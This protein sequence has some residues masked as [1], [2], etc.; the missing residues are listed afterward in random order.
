MFSHISRVF[1]LAWVACLV[2]PSTSV[3]G[4]SADPVDTL[5]LSL[6]AARKFA[7]RANPE[8]LAASW[9]PE[10]ARGD[11]R[12]A[13]TIQFNPDASFA[14]RSP[15]DG[16]SSRF[17]AEVGLELEIGGQ[18]GLR[19]RASSASL[20]GELQ[21]LDDGGRHMLANVSRAYHRL[22][23]AEQR[24]VLVEEINRLNRQLQLSVRVQLA[25]GEV[26]VLEANLAAIEATRAEA[27][28]LEAKS[29]RRSGELQLARLLG[30][31]R[32]ISLRTTGPLSM[33]PTLA[34]SGPP[35]ED[36]VRSA[37]SARPDLRAL[38]HDVERA[39]QDERLTRRE[40]LPNI[41]V[42]ALATREDPLSD[43]ELGVGFGISLPL[44]NRNQG[45]RDRRR[46]EIAEVEQLRRAAELRV[47][48]E[49][50]DAHSVYQ[51]A[52]SEVA[53]LE[54][55]MLGPIRENQSLLDT[56]YRE[57][58]LDLASLLL[59]RNQLLDAELSYWDAWERRERARTELESA[60][61][62]IL[63]GITFTNGSN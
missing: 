55:Q 33:T 4:Q 24:V 35:V 43:P 23:A 42:A 15:S 11:L 30:R 26:S 2:W 58:K 9:R 62:A 10:A 47:Q 37:L 7:A 18:R 63:D 21:R 41:R 31:E 29:A 28:T 38:E 16:M 17:E 6:S 27:R 5:V 20:S 60:T 19:G 13:R 45:Q 25:E 51:S 50:R 3:S 44:F 52:Q 56:A 48:T 54:S 46:A 8:I 40:S 32:S 61:G 59:L 49:V 22:V 14:S 53:L 1:T 12:A 39:R 57:G 34:T 36:Q